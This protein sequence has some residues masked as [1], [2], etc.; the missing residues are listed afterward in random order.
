MGTD[1]WLERWI[2]RLRRAAGA[3]PVLEIGCGPGADTQTLLQ[4]GLPVVAF[5]LSPEAVAKARLAAPAATLSVQSLLDPWPLEGAGVGVVLASLSLHYFR[6]AQTVEV[7]ARLHRTLRPGG[8]LLARFNAT[9]DIHHGATGHP[10]IEPGYFDV[11]GQPK[12]FFSEAD[13]RALFGTGWRITSL[14]H[15]VIHRYAQPKAVWEL[16]AEHS[17]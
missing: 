5:D 14:E 2:P 6:W 7:V 16:L 1:P 8:L 9:D 15:H 17:G 10:L 12:R 11:Q 13:L 3:E 4:H